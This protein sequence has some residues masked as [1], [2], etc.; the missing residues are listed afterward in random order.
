MISAGKVIPHQISVLAALA[1]AVAVRVPVSEARSIDAAPAASSPSAPATNPEDIAKIIDAELARQYPREVLSKS[2]CTADW[3]CTPKN[4][5]FYAAFDPMTHRSQG[6]V[7]DPR[8]RMLFDGQEAQLLDLLVR[9]ARA[10]F[11][12]NPVD[13]HTWIQQELSLNEGKALDF[14]LGMNQPPHGGGAGGGLPIS[15]SAAPFAVEIRYRDTLAG[16]DAAFL[17]NTGLYGARWQARHVCGGTLIAHDW[18][19]TAAH[20]I[21]PRAV[22]GKLAVQLGVT[23]VSGDGG[24]GVDVDG[25]VVHAGY[26]QGGRKLQA[27]GPYDK[28]GNIYRDDIALLHLAPDPTP[29]DPKRIAMAKLDPEPL[30]AATEV[31]AVGWGRTR[32]EGEINDVTSVLR[33]VKF[34]VLA[35]DA[36]AR[37]ADYGPQPVAAGGGQ[38]VQVARVHPGVLCVHGAG[39]KTCS[40]DSGG[41]LYRGGEPG[42]LTKLVGIVSWNKSGCHVVTDDRPGVYTR[43]SAYLEWIE[44]ARKHPLQSGQ[45]LFQ[46]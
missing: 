19:L 26:N 5:K 18:V 20:C 44:R 45:T 36:C 46:P 39:M 8:F 23:D 42:E 2:I 10:G 37:I 33:R 22:A 41:P 21:N 40:G 3:I 4:L 9:F 38:L 16:K 15:I 7:H 31:E 11:S 13:Q 1:L 35:N 14:V 27:N 29:R 32:D 17:E 24:H 30:R 25:A 12:N 43:I 34:T 6:G 28:L